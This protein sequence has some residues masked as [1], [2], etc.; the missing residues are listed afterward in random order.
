[1][2][3]AILSRCMAAKIYERMRYALSDKGEIRA[4]TNGPLELEDLPGV[5][6]TTAEKLR[7]AGFVTVESIATASPAELGRDCGDRR[8]HCKEDDQIG[9]GTG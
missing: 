5:G 2:T 3:L 7:E 4:M 8:I 9:T 6:P 1:M